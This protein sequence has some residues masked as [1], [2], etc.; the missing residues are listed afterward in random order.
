MTQENLPNEPIVSFWSGVFLPVEYKGHSIV[1]HN[2]SWTSRMTIWVD[3][4][5][6]FSKSSWRFICEQ[7]IEVGSETLATRFGWAK[8]GFI[9]EVFDGDTL[10]ASADYPMKSLGWK[11]VLSLVLLGMALGFSVEYFNFLG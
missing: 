10:V 6:V 8:R 2:S 5:A 3:G 9:F 4:E 1:A 11:Q 7:D